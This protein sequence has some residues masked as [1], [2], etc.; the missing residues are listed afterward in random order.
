MNER[1]KE[2][3]IEGTE[4]VLAGLV[5][6]FVGHGYEVI[7]ERGD[8]TVQVVRCR[9]CKWFNNDHNE[10]DGWMTCT[11]LRQEVDKEWFCRSGERKN[12]GEDQRD[13]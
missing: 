7:P 11:L 8:G 6:R 4:M 13:S 12:D 1:E 3:L 5:G 2:I 10:V 9:D